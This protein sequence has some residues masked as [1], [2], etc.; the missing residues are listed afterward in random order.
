MG[1]RR[2]V[3]R[4]ERETEGE[5]MN[6]RCPECGW[7]ITVFGDPPLDLIVYRWQQ[8]QPK[9]EESHG[10]SFATTHPS[11]ARL[12]EHEHRAEDFLEKHSGL[13]LFSKEVSGMNLG[14]VAHDA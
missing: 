4:L 8:G 14:G 5:K 11:L 7:E 12:A 10:P 3:K 13:P 6:L 1:L 2:W 9:S